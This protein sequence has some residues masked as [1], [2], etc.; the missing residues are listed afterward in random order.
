MDT[1]DDKI[2]LLN[3]N[4]KKKDLYVD[5]GNMDVLI[6]DIVMQLEIIENNFSDIASILNKAIY[7]KIFNGSDVEKVL[8]LSKD[9]LTSGGNNLKV[10]N[11]LQIKYNSNIKSYELKK[12]NERIDMLERKIDIITEQGGNLNDEG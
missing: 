10:S 2:I 6:D 7:K 4:I 8:N 9:F 12:L 1:K 11:N 3:K 5:S